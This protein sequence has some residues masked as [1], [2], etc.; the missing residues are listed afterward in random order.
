MMATL[1]IDISNLDC[2]VH[3]YVV[4][5]TNAVIPESFWGTKSNFRLVL[6]S[7]AFISCLYHPES[8]SI[9]IRR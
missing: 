4:L 7:K 6:H 1:E 9:D 5:V 8:K 2:K 3:R